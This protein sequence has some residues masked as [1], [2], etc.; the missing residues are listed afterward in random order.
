MPLTPGTSLG[1]FEVGDLLGTGGMGEVYRA[2]DTRLNRTVALKI[3][4]DSVAK[5]PDRLSRFRR[6]AQLLASLSHPNIA[7]IHGLEEGGP[8]PALVLE[9]VEGPTLA[10]RLSRGPMPIAD[11]QAAA[12]Q[13]AEALEAAHDKSIVHRDLKPANIKLTPGGRVKILDFG[14]AKETTGTAGRDVSHSPTELRTEPGLI[15]GTAPYMSP[16]Q[17]KGIDTDPRTDIWA[18]GCV[19]YEMLTG[20]RAFDGDSVADVLGAIMKSE[21]DWSVLPPDTPSGLRRLLE[22]CLR[23]DRSRRLRH[24]G[25]AWLELEESSDAATAKPNGLQRGSHRWERLAWSV[26]VVLAA[27]AAAIAMWRGRPAAPAQLWHVEVD[28]PPFRNSLPAISPDGRKIVYIA[29]VDG[30]TSLWVRPVDSPRAQALPGTDGAAAPFWSPDGRSVAFFTGLSQLRRVD[31]D[32]G[33]ATIHRRPALIGLG[34]AWSRDGTILF[35]ANPSSPILRV[36]ADGGEAVPVTRLLAPHQRLHAAPHLLPDDRHFIYFVDGA[37]EARGVYLGELGRLESRLLTTSEA[38]GAYASGHLVFVRNGRLLAQAFDLERLTLNGEPVV[39]ADDVNSGTTVSTSATGTIVYRT[40]PEDTGERQLVWMDRTGKTL[41]RVVYAGREA[42]GPALSGDGRRI[43]L[44]RDVNGN[45]DIWTYDVARRTWDRT[46]SDPLDDIYPLWSP[47]GS[48]LIFASNRVNGSMNLYLKALGALGDEAPLLKTPQVKFPTDW[49]RDGRFVVYNQLAAEGH[50]DVWA[51]PL[52]A[53]RTPFPVIRSEFNEQHAQLSPDGTW[54]AYQ[55][56]RTGRFEVYL[57]RFAGPGEDLPVST[58]GGAQPRW[59]PR[60]REMFYI[61]ADDRLT[62]VPL[63]FGADGRSV[64]PGRPIGLFVTN[65]G[66][67]AINTNRHQYM[68]SPDGQSFVM[69]SATDSPS[70]APIR[71]ILNW[72]PR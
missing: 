14:L 20:R 9:L 37:P 8:M 7:A 28:A 5:D 50:V 66:S 42:Q 53:D 25:D 63:S 57:R 51:A 47:D 1:P 26:A 15:L 2:R 58:N 12:R 49:S 13:I 72:K 35:A 16:E 71:M 69:N 30:R 46:T 43:A 36:P 17:A 19:L 4:P 10:D 56:D 55:S 38:P 70:A 61:A 65:V 21:P 41:D 3:L 62:A 64:E 60:G 68:V 11:V 33:S 24:I 6:E 67:T 18:F 34:G 23:K 54:L 45:V 31:L 48:R 27:A 52:D 39:V 44:F 40:A 29:R 32:G 22:R 59:H